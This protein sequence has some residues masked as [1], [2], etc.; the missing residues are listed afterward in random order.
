M[1]EDDA[2]MI[3]DARYARRVADEERWRSLCAVSGEVRLAAEAL[4]RVTAERDRQ[5]RSAA[6][7]EWT[8]DK[9]SAATLVTTHR[10]SQVLRRERA[11]AEDGTL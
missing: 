1:N 6:D 5:I 10:I 9:I 3:I 8:Y 2:K 4:R 7:A 11:R